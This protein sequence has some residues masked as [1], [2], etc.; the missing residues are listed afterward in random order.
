MSNKAKGKK[1]EINEILY[2]FFVNAVW[3]IN[4]EEEGDGT[5]IV[6]I[7]IDGALEKSDFD[8][9]ANNLCKQLSGDSRR[10]ELYEKVVE[11]KEI[12]EE[13]EKGS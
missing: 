11:W 9:L 8:K 1:T 2:W 10:K 7:R 4:I 13:E 12:I 5:K 6:F 3:D